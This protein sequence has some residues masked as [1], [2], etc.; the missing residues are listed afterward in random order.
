MVLD[1]GLTRQPAA[2][3]ALSAAMFTDLAGWIMLAIV[4]SLSVAG[5]ESATWLRVGGGLIAFVVSSIAFV[6]LIVR[7]LAA[8]AAQTASARPLVGVV[9]PYLL[10]SAWATAALG[11]HSAFGS[12]VAARRVRHPGVGG[13]RDYGDDRTA[14]SSRPHARYRRSRPERPSRPLS[15]GDEIRFVSRITSARADAVPV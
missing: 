12:L 8:R 7:P 1:L 3:L 2:K 15:Q 4:A 5:V 6:R 13:T 11:L 10:V 9:V 14:R